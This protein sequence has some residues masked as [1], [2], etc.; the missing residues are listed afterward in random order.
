MIGKAGRV[1][2]MWAM[3]ITQHSH[4]A[5]ASTALSNLLLVTGNYGRPGTG[6]YPMRGHNNVQGASD[7]GCLKNFYPGYESVSDPAVRA[8]WANA[9]GVP[10]ERLS[11]EVGEDNFMMVKMAR[12]K[13][14]RAM[15]V[16]GEDTAFADA[17]AHS[18]H[19]GFTDLDFLVV[20][21][22]FLSRTAQ[23]ADVV[24]PGCP[25]VEKRAAL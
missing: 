19:E 1:C 16:I 4:G 5:D 25:S 18:V 11:L 3:G 23:F 21:D 9:W 2:I 14:I 12:E 8:K 10:A 6:G 24:L 20:Q 17:D 7:F 15:Y 22:L 13:Q